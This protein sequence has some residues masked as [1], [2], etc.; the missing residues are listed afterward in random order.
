MTAQ[1]ILANL[2]QLEKELKS[3]SSAR[4]LVEK[5]VTAYKEVQGDIKIF[6]SDFQ[7]VIDSLNK[8]SN[9]F[10]S[11]KSTLTTD[12]KTTI[13]VLKDQLD[14]LNKAFANQ[15]NAIVIGF[16]N[17]TKDA[18]NEFKNTTKS[19]TSDYELNNAALKARITELSTVQGTI[20]KAVESVA[21]IKTDITT[22][23]TQL[24]DSRQHQ[25][26][27]LQS[28]AAE[29]KSIGTRND[30]ILSKLSEEL[31]QSH[32]DQDKDLDV[33]KQAQKAQFDK[34]D[35]VLN[36]EEKLISGIELTIST[37]NE[38]I[39]YID[40]LLNTVKQNLNDVSSKLNVIQAKQDTLAS[41]VEYAKTGISGLGNL[42]NNKS[43]EIYGR[44]DEIINL[45]KSAK[46]ML[47]V[48]IVICII[49]LVV[50]L[51]R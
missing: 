15:C 50:T 14:I 11:E 32:E 37:I 48:N 33:L 1:E 8:I 44:F 6:F 12:V 4:L 24:T 35:S 3:I 30:E 38:K 27:T 47:V 31:K 46:T 36:E 9:A 26:A 16:V 39:V 13:N 43:K 19:L 42:I 40:T 25:D 29:L 22:L 51:F 21:T 2:S 28:I 23:Q 18:A 41:A 45:N 10:E 7:K 17:G 5:T 49:V 34:M 20:S